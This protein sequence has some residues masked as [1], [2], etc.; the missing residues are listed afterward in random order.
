M[1]STDRPSISQRLRELADAIELAPALGALTPISFYLS[2]RTVE[3]TIALL[4]AI[5]GP[6]VESSA[7]DTLWIDGKVAGF[8]VSV[9]VPQ[10]ARTEVVKPALATPITELLTRRAHIDKGVE[11]LA[12]WHGCSD[13]VDQAAEA[14]FARQDVA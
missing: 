9:T 13:S 12:T 1:D 4:N 7:R 11:A 5:D 2:P 6:L 14:H 10:C 8:R 3:E